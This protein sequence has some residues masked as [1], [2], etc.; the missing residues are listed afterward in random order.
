MYPPS[1]SEAS[2]L[3]LWAQ[4]S[5]L[6]LQNGVLYRQWEDVPCKGLH[7]RL[8]LVLPPN[9]VPVL[10]EAL[11]SSIRGGHFETSKTLAKVRECFYWVG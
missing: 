4:S 7:R 11:H 3:A 1:I 2:V 8:Q 9:L 10:L 6:V 5:Y